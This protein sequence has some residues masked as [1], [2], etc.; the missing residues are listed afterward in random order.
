MVDRIPSEN[1]V[2]SFQWRKLYVPIQIVEH[3][4]FGF[5]DIR[6]RSAPALELISRAASSVGITYHSSGPKTGSNPRGRGIIKN[7]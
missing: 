6:P 7:K 4:A 5:I 1:G 3:R 2:L